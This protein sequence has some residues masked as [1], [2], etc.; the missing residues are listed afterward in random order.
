MLVGNFYFSF[1]FFRWVRMVDGCE[2][3]MDY[4]FTHFCEWDS[5]VAKK[6]YETVRAVT[7]FQA[8]YKNNEKINSWDLV[9]CVRCLYCY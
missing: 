9:D 6:S 8:V 5:F 1:L 2:S 7:I 4:G 3:G